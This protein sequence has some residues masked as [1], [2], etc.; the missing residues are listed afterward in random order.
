M[1]VAIYTIALDEERFAQRF[2]D[3][4]REA[5]LI[6]VADSGSKDRTAEIIE[7]NG[8]RVFPIRIRPWRFDVARNTALSALPGDIDVCIALDLDEVLVEGWRDALEARFRPGRHQRVRFRF[9]HSYKH[10]GSYGTIGR[11]EFIHARDGYLWRYPVHERAF[12]VGAQ[13]EKKIEIPELL[14][15]HRQDYGKSRASYLSLLELACREPAASVRHVF[16]LAREYIYA[17]RW[18]DAIDTFESFLASGESWVV[19]QAFA[20]LLLSQAREARGEVD[21]ARR[22][23]LIATQL[24]PR[25][26][27]PW[28]ALAGFNVRRQEWTQAYLAIKQALSIDHR[29]EHYLVRE[30]CWDWQPHDLAALCAFKL[31]ELNASRKHLQDALK[32]APDRRELVEKSRRLASVETA[33]RF[34]NR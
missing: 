30:E 6:L 1:K 7:D 16:W 10:D 26:R 5:D 33:S 25:H 4:C 3:C 17:R 22:H 18:S 21:L 27:E 20:H 14:V 34:F 28:L 2:M 11:K 12:W 32:R 29:C 13:E 31:G 9:V 24:L 8:G 23:L 15:E 19:E